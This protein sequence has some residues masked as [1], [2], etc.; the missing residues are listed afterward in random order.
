MHANRSA[1]QMEDSAAH[2]VAYAVVLA[3]VSVALVAGVQWLML[4][5]SLSGLVR[6]LSD[7]LGA[8]VCISSTL[9]H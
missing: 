2:A 7:C 3:L 6:R 8:S 9:G 4:A 5:E 1:P